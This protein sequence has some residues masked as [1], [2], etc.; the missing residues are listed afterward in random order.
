VTR[1]GAGLACLLCLAAAAAAA[2]PAG[3]GRSVLVV[4]NRQAAG[5]LE[6]AARYRAARGVPAANQVVLDA[7]P[8]EVIDWP[9]LE[10]RILA[11]VRKA[12]AARPDILYIVP[13]Y[14]V[15]L[16]VWPRGSKGGR[17]GRQCAVDAE[18]ALLRRRGYRVQGYFPNP[19][20]KRKEA[21]GKHLRL[22][23]VC[24]LDGPSAKAAA[25]LVDAALA[26]ERHGLRG[27]AYLDARGLRGSDVYAVGDADVRAAYERLRDDG[28][29]PARL[30]NTPAV[31]DLA[32]LADP[33]F[34]WGWY[35]QHVL[36]GKP[37][38]FAPGAV[39]VH[40]HSGSAKTVRAGDRH[41]VGPLVAAGAAGTMGTVHE[42]Y[43][44]TYPKAA[45]FTD[46]FL[47]GYN[48]A[49]SC[50]MASPS[51]SWQ[52]VY[53][54]D[55]LYRP[56]PKDLSAAEAAKL[57]AAMK[58]CREGLADKA[59]ARAVPAVQAALD[60][61]DRN[62]AYAKARAMKGRLRTAAAARLRAARA[63]MRAGRTGEGLNGLAAVAETFAGLPE[64][65]L[66]ARMRKAAEAKIEARMREAW[67][68]S[69]RDKRD[70]ANAVYRDVVRRLPGTR[71]AREA[72][73]RLEESVLEK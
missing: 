71:W 26:G 23:L 16:R 47:S 9:V 56:F 59:Y 15:P 31:Q 1:Y 50:Y 63:A 55:P 57:D 62:P 11:P 44:T 25:A 73:A 30:E 2:R 69:S 61:G 48:F 32:T 22:L 58:A 18:L 41:W 36:A 51:L 52:N 35:R 19:Y 12:L 4:A 45:V 20:F 46:R 53:V 10:E 13:V 60:F 67:D 66:A 54:G 65:V 39:A 37:F 24:R 72:A 28:R 21:V 29:I 64:A 43:L 6:V 68:L 7:P 5:S 14:G 40:I 34:Y 8:D 33:V 49:E 3:E 27:T 17:N 38:R 70:A 42:P